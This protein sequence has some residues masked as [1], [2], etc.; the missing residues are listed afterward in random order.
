MIID[1][2]KTIITSKK[3]IKIKKAGGL[4]QSQIAS[5]LTPSNEA[6]FT[7]CP[8]CY[9]IPS[10]SF[11]PNDP[12]KVKI[13]CLC[14]YSSTT[15]TKDYLNEYKSKQKEIYHECDG[16]KHLPVESAVAF[17]PKCKIWL[18][19]ECLMFHNKLSPD[20][21][22]NSS[23]VNVNDYCEVHCDKKI[24]LF[25]KTCLKHLCADC[26]KEHLE[27]QIINL[28]ELYEKVD[29]DKIK[30]DF[31]KAEKMVDTY[32][33][34][35]KEKIVK[36]LKKEIDTIE[37]LYSSNEQ[38]NKNILRMVSVFIH[39]YNHVKEVKD[40]NNIFNLI[41]HTTF[42]FEQCDVNELYPIS[43]NIQNIKN[44]FSNHT[45][46][47]YALN[48]DKAFSLVKSIPQFSEV[49]ALTLMND[50]R[51]ASGAS[52]K[53]IHIYN[54]NSFKCDIDIENAHDDRIYSLCPLN[55]NNDIVSCSEDSIIKIWD[56][57]S[58]HN[59]NLKKVIRG[60]EDSVNK[61]IALSLNRFASCSFD[62]KIKIWSSKSYD[63][64]ST[65]EEHSHSV[66]SMIQLK[67]KE[68]LV[69][70]SL[71]NKLKF[72]NLNLYTCEHTIN[73]IMNT[74]TEGI[75]EIKNNRIVVSTINPNKLV[76]VNTNEH[77]IER[78]IDD[79]M[80]RNLSWCKHGVF[81]F[82]R[83]KENM[84]LCGCPN[85][86]LFQFDENNLAMVDTKEKVHQEGVHSLI[87]IDDKRYV[88][89]S[90]D[91]TIKIFE[92]V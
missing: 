28:K 2:Q 33:K 16:V 4:S 14:S 88:T 27:H 31:A 78:S 38:I 75:F 46:I 7:Q 68:I 42:N 82:I 26:I 48:L 36:K 81:S 8:L 13:K 65:M 20:H 21:N 10:I 44:Y 90:T 52:D 22:T 79:I 11:L 15:D 25:C 84:I 76:I 45:I 72:W 87:K 30:A 19:K 5:P 17:C 66:T 70:T 71:D 41:N 23:K 92:Y 56:I 86:G 91:G 57:L 67:G 40:Y 39:N 6:I 58:E 9:R 74:A 29:I 35:L 32:N 73:N 53:S 55:T 18:C 77:S 62:T 1:K 85:G 37:S 49:Y 34:E 24:I 63:N 59:Y 60:H 61:V 43:K 80:F 83:L 64:I 54:G 3:I 69:S 12:K 89:A 51:I 47:K 50:G